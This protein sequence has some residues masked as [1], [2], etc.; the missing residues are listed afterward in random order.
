VGDQDQSIYGFRGCDPEML[1]AKFDRDFSPQV[2]YLT[3][4]YRSQ[5]RILDAAFNLIELN[6]NQTKRHRLRGLDDDDDDDGGDNNKEDNVNVISVSNEVE[7]AKYITNEILQIQTHNDK[8][9]DVG[10]LMRTN[11]QFRAIE[12]ELIRNKI[13]HV[14]INGTRFFD[15]REIRDV[16]AYTKCLLNPKDDLALER[17]INVPRRNV[18]DKTL[19]SIRRVANEQGISMWCALE[20]HLDQIKLQSKS[21][22]PF[23]DVMRRLRLESENLSLSETIVD[24]LQEIG[25]E[26]YCRD[27]LD[28][29]ESRWSHV[30]E[31]VNSAS[32]FHFR[33]AQDWL[34]EVALLSNPESWSSTD[35]R[36]EQHDDDDNDN[37]VV[38]SVKLMTI[39]QSKGNEFS[40]VFVAGVEEDLLPHHYALIGEY[41]NRSKD[42]EEERRCMYVAL[43]RA[44]CSAHLT[45][46]RERMTWGRTRDM[47][48]SRFLG[49]IAG[50]WGGAGV[51][52][53]WLEDD[54]RNRRV[55]SYN[56]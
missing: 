11:A 18:G 43:T 2:F 14:I 55:K 42:V 25:Y 51:C 19:L 50:G 45:T 35:I 29:G 4:N 40:H 9:A 30:R 36:R 23:V 39:H 32:R 34:D 56:I 48:P 10:V 37:G 54:D 31:L 22:A 47:E 6:N 49:E 21:L 15:R 44:K 13:N 5:Q 12:R 16:V 17:I 26:T 24:M 8:H 46:S 27:E 1:M 20:N 41:D 28:S 3:R 33:N 53:K 52:W 7:E 38:P